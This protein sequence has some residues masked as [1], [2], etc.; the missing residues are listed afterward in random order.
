ML[1]TA[2]RVAECKTIRF[3]LRERSGVLR[4]ISDWWK[5]ESSSKGKLIALRKLAA[6]LWEFTRDS[7]PQ[8]R[9]SRYGD[10]DFDWDHRVNTTGATVSARN[11]LL[12]LFHSPYQP[13]DPALFHEMMAAL[14]IDFAHFT[15]LDIGFGKGRALLLAADYPFRRI[16]GVELLPELHRIAQ[17]NIAKYASDSQKCSQLEI[18]CADATEFQFPADPLLLYLF[19]PLPEPALETTLTRLEN[20]WR[21]SHRP[22]IVLYHNPVLEHVFIRRTAWQKI[23]GTLQYA[24]FGLLGHSDG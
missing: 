19:N 7:T 2:G 18:V 5:Q 12:G 16:V 8:R 1:F 10:A 21:E 23:G 13:T 14:A 17:E 24:I 11:R 15:F 3:V 4:T 9:R 6:I 20:S 22:I